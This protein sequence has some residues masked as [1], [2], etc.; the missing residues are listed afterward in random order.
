MTDKSTPFV[1]RAGSKL[2][3][4]LKEFG[5]N[6]KGLIC[7]DFGCNSGGFTDCLLQSGAKKVYAV[8]T[9][10]NCLDWNLRHKDSVVIMEQYNAMHVRLPEK[11][12]LIVSDVA[13]TRQVNIL[14]SIERNLKTDGQAITLIKPHYEAEREQLEKGKVADKYLDE[15]VENMRKEFSKAGFEVVGIV[16]S[17]IKGK[18][19]GNTEFLAHLKLKKG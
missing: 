11:V 4:A 16:E 13:W 12:D 17:P 3:H 6:P 10:K 19:G 5:V 1:S 2:D 15:I 8:D 14:P 9:A 7:A 18:S